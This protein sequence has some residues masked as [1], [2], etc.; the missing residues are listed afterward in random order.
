MP[1]LLPDRSATAEEA[2]NRHRPRGITIRNAAETTEATATGAEA[3]VM[4]GE[5]SR[6]FGYI[7]TNINVT[8]VVGTP[9]MRIVMITMIPH[10]AI[11]IVHAK[12]GMTTDII[13]DA[14]VVTEI[15]TMSVT[16]MI[17][18]IDKSVLLGGQGAR[19]SVGN[20][21]MGELEAGELSL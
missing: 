20:A 11:D 6:Y 5:G 12:T 19:A 10:L 3:G 13:P 9:T 17:T 7:N 2:S 1:H 21:V 4:K 15:T 18:A 16:G 8:D 14:T